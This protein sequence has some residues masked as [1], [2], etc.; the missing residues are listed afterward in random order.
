MSACIYGLG[1]EVNVPIA[2]LAGLGEAK[3]IDVSMTIGS[4]PFDLEE[5]P[6]FISAHEY[7]VSPDLDDAGRPALRAA[8]LLDSKYHR[9][10]YCDGTTVVVDAAG[11]SVWATGPDSAT[12]EDTAIYLLG[13]ILG[14]V[15]RLRGV[16][17]LHASAVA[18]DGRAVALVGPSGAGKSSTA[19]AFARLG[20][21]VLTDDVLAL[22][23]HGDRF[24]VQPAYP[25]VRLWEDSVASIFGKYDA[26]PLISPAWDKRFLDLNGP[27]SRF[28]A[29]SL[30]LGAIYFLGDRSDSAD[31]PTIEEITPRT[32]LMHLVSD[33]YATRLLQPA[34]RAREFEVLGRVVTAVPLRR[35]TPSADF[36]RIA[37]LCGAVISDF[38]ERQERD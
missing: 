22:V 13:P 26:L 25:R 35:V 34:L 30:Q 27:E 38:Q 31:A 16:I 6:D 37:D 15:L 4:M 23:D 1:L 36:G 20:H 3:R 12:V 17:C 9:I 24:D 19:A 33:T 8:S 5:N 7:Y 10:A 28:Q 29:E 2:G 21:R 11:S 14:F 32:G 18:I